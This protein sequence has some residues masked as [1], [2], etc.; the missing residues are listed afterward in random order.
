MEGRPVVEKIEALNTEIAAYNA[1]MQK[2]AEFI[3]VIDSVEILNISSKELVKMTNFFEKTALEHLHIGL[4]LRAKILELIPDMDEE[5]RHSIIECNSRISLLQADLFEK[6]IQ[7][8]LKI[9]KVT[10]DKMINEDEGMQVLT[11]ERNSVSSWSFSATEKY[12]C[13]E[14]SMRIHQKIKWIICG[15]LWTELPK[16]DG[17]TSSLSSPVPV[18]PIEKSGGGGRLDPIDRV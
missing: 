1:I 4:D 17:E 8:G 10:I 16:K 6:I 14:E 15:K 3:I 11:K 12:F 2:L 9:P 5:K 13:Q 7:S 18:K